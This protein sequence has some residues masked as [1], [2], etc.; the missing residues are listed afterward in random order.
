VILFI[1]L[2]VIPD[3]DIGLTLLRRSVALVGVTLLL[4]GLTHELK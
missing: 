2:T 3:I 4:Y 1:D